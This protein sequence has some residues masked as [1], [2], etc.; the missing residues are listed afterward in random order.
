MRPALLLNSAKQSETGIHYQAPLFVYLF[1][2]LFFDGESNES[3]HCGLFTNDC[4]K[5]QG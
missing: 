4:S 3:E 1:F 2:V 5:R